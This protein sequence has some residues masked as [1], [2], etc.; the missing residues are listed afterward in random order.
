MMWEISGQFRIQIWVGGWRRLLHSYFVG[1]PPAPAP[2]LWRTATEMGD[3]VQP[4]VHAEPRL[5]PPP[6]RR[7]PKTIKGTTTTTQRKDAV[8]RRVI[9]TE[10]RSRVVSVEPA[11][12]KTS[13]SH[14][15]GR[16]GVL[17]SQLSVPQPVSD[18]QLWC[19]VEA[20]LARLRTQWIVDDATSPDATS[21]STGSGATPVPALTSQ[22]AAPAP[23]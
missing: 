13:R 17:P 2:A 23:T 22:P 20:E 21:S 7:P 18:E 15:T 10:P 12:V 4:C 14:T 5:A 11:V 16:A 3:A 19:S 1:I 8:A 9:V 6:K